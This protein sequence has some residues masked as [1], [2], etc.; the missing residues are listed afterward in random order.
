MKRIT[1][2]ATAVS[3]LALLALTG[4]AAA[5]G[6]PTASVDPEYVGAAGEH[7]VTVSGSGW[8]ADPA[9]T[10]CTGWGG[11]VP[12]TLDQASTLANCPDLIGDMGA[13]VSAPGG[14]FSTS[15]TINVPAEGLVILVFTAQP[16]AA[17]L[18]LVKVGEPMAD[19]DM[20]DDDM[21]DDD[22]TDD[23][24]DDDMTD[25]MA[26][27]DMADDD[28]TDDDMTDDMADDDM[29]DDMADDDMADDDM[30]DDMAP[31]GPAATGYGGSAGSDGNSIAVPLAATL[32]AVVLLGGAVLVTRR[33]V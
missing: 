23:M 24:A 5:Q 3:L 1:A 22:M 16:S 29:T 4:H 14:S 6:E 31:E 28:M 15:V 21:A 26:D 10:A 33:N 32:A 20:A 2:I 25:D 8:Q 27:D 19:D 13:P 17:A 30:A 7:T 18:T 9:I 12:S 11:V